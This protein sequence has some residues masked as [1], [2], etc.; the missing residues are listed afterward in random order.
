MP[1]ESKFSIMCDEVRVENNG[2]FMIIGMYTP[3]MTVPQLPFVLPTL[4]FL[5]WLQ[6]DRI[7]NVQFRASLDH[8]ESGVG[9]AQAMGGFQI[10]GNQGIVLPIRLQGIR[11]MNQGPYTFSMS[12]DGQPPV[13]HP[14]NVILR[15]PNVP[16]MPGAPGIPGVHG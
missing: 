6:T 11:F 7:G 15:I 1:I 12:F 2:K 14:F 16:G 5:L 3:D 9:V 10:I 13:T 4:T 8:L